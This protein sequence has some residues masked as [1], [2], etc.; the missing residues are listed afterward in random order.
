MSNRI[1]NI[2]KTMIHRIN[3]KLE[4]V[5]RDNKLTAYLPLPSNVV[6]KRNVQ[7]R[8]FGRFLT[9]E[10]TGNG[11]KAE[12]H[13]KTSWKRAYWNKWRDKKTNIQT[14]S[15]TNFFNLTKEIKT[16]IETE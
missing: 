3:R 8:Q 14:F 11:Y 10:N 15:G 2:E 6:T 12:L 13:N 16:A 1:T 5:V 9:I 7:F 4:I